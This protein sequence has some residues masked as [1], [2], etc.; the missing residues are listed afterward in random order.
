MKVGILT[1]HRAHNYGAV[2][3]CYALQERLKLAG[4]DVYIIDYRQPAIE[5]AYKIFDMHYF[6]ESFCHPKRMLVYLKALGE[7]R[8]TS[9][10]FEKF[11]SK[12][13][14]T[15][16]CSLSTIPTNFDAYIIGSDQLWV[17][18]WTGGELDKV[19]AGQFLRGEKSKLFSYAISVNE[20]SI[21][22]ISEHEWSEIA[23]NF[24]VLSFREEP[25]AKKMA[26]IIHREVRTD[27]DPTLL[28]DSLQWN[29]I[30]NDT[31][32]NEKYLLVYH[33]PGR[34]AGMSNE[35]F[36]TRIDKIA[37]AMQCKV[38]SLYPMKY[39]VS[40]FVSLFKYAK[41]VITTSFHATVFSLIFERPL[42]SIVLNDGLDN[43]YVSL[44]DKVHAS[45]ALV[46][47]NMNDGIF[48][49]L[50]YGEIREQILLYVKPSVEYLDSFIDK[51][52]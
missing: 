5:S 50:Q 49:T 4:Y 23:S 35:E 3:Q 21:N 33:L 34:F 12:I 24:S 28:L 18:K 20:T 11:S 37:K 42:M 16:P 39:S 26:S 22:G 19:Y 15:T 9:S 27:I 46:G 31:W 38:I 14:K 29:N 7:R 13:R 36:M 2:L 44:L 43:R 17:A 40:D 45:K 48:P 8:R 51:K 41:G 47:K 30:T 32:K 1:F 6:L 52:L 25:M 10:V